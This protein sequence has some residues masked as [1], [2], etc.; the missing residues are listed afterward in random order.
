MSD[1]SDFGTFL[2]GFIVGGLTGAAVALLLAPQSGEE[3]RTIIKEKAIELK[4]K[5]S[6]TYDEVS[7]KASV[8]ASDAKVKAEEL[9]KEATKTV[10]EI[11]TKGQVVLEENKAKLTSRFSKKDKSLDQDVAI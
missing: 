6:E 3:T 11:K 10:G 5:A 4:D 8:I 2:V 1:R 9:K 7:D